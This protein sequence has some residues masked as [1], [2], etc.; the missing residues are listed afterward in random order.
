MREAARGSSPT[1]PGLG[2]HLDTGLVA[3]NIEL[4]RNDMAEN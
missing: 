2:S 1:L 4:L 3:S